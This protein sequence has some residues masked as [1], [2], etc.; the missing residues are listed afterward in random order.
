MSVS[1]SLLVSVR[2][3]EELEAACF[4]GADIIDVKEP[5]NGS[6]GMASIETLRAIRDRSYQ[7]HATNPFSIALGELSDWITD[8]GLHPEAESRAVAMS[9]LKP[10]FVKLG[11]TGRNDWRNDWARV[12]VLPFGSVTW[13]AVAYADFQHV[14]APSPEQVLAEA[15]SVGCR[16]LLIDTFLKDGRGLLDWMSDQ[17]LADI[18]DVAI[19]AGMQLALAGSLSVE[20]LPTI[21]RIA[22]EIV[23]VRGAVCD[24][25]DRRKGVDQ[26][27]VAGFR[28]QM[29]LVN[30]LVSP[31]GEASESR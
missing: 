1:C 22:P 18:H 9:R 29:V 30:G 21:L 20:T 31:L 12:R 8:N 5:D 10:D 14:D 6:L 17:Q 11:L 13:V 7:L 19:Q 16:I 24:R 26:C 3:A 27:L 2:N 23:A 15:R 25:G 28:R 4:G